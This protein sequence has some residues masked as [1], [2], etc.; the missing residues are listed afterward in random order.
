MTIGNIN[1]QTVF[2]PPLHSSSASSFLHL[3]TSRG[4]TFSSPTSSSLYRLHLHHAVRLASPVFVLLL[5]AVAVILNF[6]LIVLVECE[7]E[8]QQIPSTRRN[9]ARSPRVIGVDGASGAE[10]QAASLVEEESVPAEQRVAVA[11]GHSAALI[12]GYIYSN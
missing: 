10:I 11:F 8:K 9:T 2:P 6:I 3:Y 4:F 7:A 5:L 1:I 12:L